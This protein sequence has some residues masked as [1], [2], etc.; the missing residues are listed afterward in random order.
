M[1]DL[2]APF[3]LAIVIADAVHIDPSN[4]KAFIMGTFSTIQAS[5][6]PGAHQSIGVFISLTGGRGNVP[7]KATLVRTGEDEE[8]I[9]Q[10]EAELEFADPRVIVDLVLTFKDIVFAEPG[11]YR[12]QLYAAGEFMIERRFVVLSPATEEE[13]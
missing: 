1:P 12:V 10:A 2:P 5:A 4:G 9:A 7:I 3:P 6:F 11:E 13:R 8:T